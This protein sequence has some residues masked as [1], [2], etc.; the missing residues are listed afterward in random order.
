MRDE[1]QIIWEALEKAKTEKEKEIRIIKA[2]MDKI[3]MSDWKNE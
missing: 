1:K 2:E 3:F